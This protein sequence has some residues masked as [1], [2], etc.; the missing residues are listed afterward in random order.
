VTRL[1]EV[2]VK[3]GLKAVIYD[4]DDTLTRTYFT[5]GRK[6]YMKALEE[7]IGQPIDE[8]KFMK[9]WYNDFKNS[10]PLFQVNP[11]THQ[12][13]SK[14]MA[15]KFGVDF[16]D[17]RLQL[18]Y[19]EMW[20]VIYESIPENVAGAFESVQMFKAAGLDVGVATHGQYDWT[21]LK[22]TNWRGEF[23]KV[24]CI[25]V[26]GPKGPSQWLEAMELMGAKPV[27]CIVAGDNVES[28]IL[29]ALELGV[30]HV[31]RVAA[32]WGSS[33]LPEGVCEVHDLRE[34]VSILISQI[35]YF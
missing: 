9:D 31:F 30:K 19:Q 1:K 33:P 22:L 5:E 24:H 21:W 16:N 15:A 7:L 32:S 34:M 18:A 10:K 6:I 29:P 3:E 35:S 13:T 12:H 26:N 11:L 8:E 2:V 27:E 4:L 25:D 20:R 23:K 28:D 14:K 17:E